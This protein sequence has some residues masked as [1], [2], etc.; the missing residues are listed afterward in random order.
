[1]KPTVQRV[2]L[3]SVVLTLVWFVI[4]YVSLSDEV[5]QVKASIAHHNTELHK[6]NPL[7]NFKAASVSRGGFPFAFTVKVVRP[8]LTM[9][10]NDE[11]FAV[12][13]PSV[14][15]SKTQASEGRYRFEPVTYLE[16]LYAKSG[17]PPEQYKVTLN[18]A[19]KLAVRA[20]GNSAQ[21]SNLPGMRSCPQPEKHAPFIS[22]AASLPALLQLTVTLDD[23]SKTIEFKNTEMNMPV[24]F[25]I[26]ADS[27]RALVLFVGMLREAMV[28]GHS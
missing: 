28:Y 20:I 8:T 4:W 23:K 2:V 22:A 14:A 26:P 16:A 9:I 12:S 15:L 1:M 25:T 21:C 18:A 17:Q 6:A 3:T 19:P 24:F 5:A 7:A 27:S 11:T 10:W 13:I